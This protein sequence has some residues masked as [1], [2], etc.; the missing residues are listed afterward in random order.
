MDI[1]LFV[2]EVDRL[3]EPTREALVYLVRNA[4]PNLRTVLAARA[5]CRLEID[6]LIAY[7]S[8]TVVGSAQLRFQLDETMELVRTRFGTGSTATPW[9][10]CTN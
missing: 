9:R 5:D 8:C 3:P 4:P 10:G 1:V 6:D 2:D 7:G